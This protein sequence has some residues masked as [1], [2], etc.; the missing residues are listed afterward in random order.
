MTKG[1]P[2]PRFPT[3][4][5]LNQNQQAADTNE[6]TEPALDE[7]LPPG[8]RSAPAGS[9][10]SGSQ[11]P[12]EAADL[13]AGETAVKEELPQ[14]FGDYE[15]LEEIAR[16]GMGVVYRARDLKL[17]REVGLKMILNDKLADDSDIERFYSEA[18]SAAALKHPGVVPVYDVGERNGQHFFS[19]GFV[20][21]ESLA[22]LIARNPL[23]PT[24]SAQMVKKISEAI[25]YAHGEGVIHR[26]LKPANVLLDSKRNPHISDFGL[27]KKI[28]ADSNLTMPGQVIGTPSYMPPEQASGET[29]LIGP[30]ADV[31]SLGAVLYCCLTGR[32]PFQA[33][34]PME[35]LRQ[36][37]ERDP[38]PPRQLNVQIDRDLDT[39]CL[40]CLEKDPQRRYGSA[41]EIVDELERFLNGQPIR[42]RR[43]PVTTTLLTALFLTLVGGIAGINWWQK[44]AERRAIQAEQAEESEMSMDADVSAEVS[45][46]ERGQEIA[47]ALLKSE[48][49]DFHEANSAIES[50]TQRVIATRTGSMTDFDQQQKS[51]LERSLRYY[52]QLAERHLDDEKKSGT[53]IRAYSMSGEI[54]AAT[55][56]PSE[57]LQSYQQVLHLLEN[58]PDSMSKGDLRA[59]LGETSFELARL[60]GLLDAKI[61][62]SA[63]YSV[64]QKEKEHKNHQEQVVFL[65]G[66]AFAQGY[67]EVPEHL[68]RLKKDVHFLA[69]RS[70][71][72]GVKLFG[73]IDKA[74]RG[75]RK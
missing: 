39:I 68:D 16:G 62:G 48:R 53:V 34:N 6:V 37:V 56:R 27:A 54:L 4:E 57:A 55:E 43:I 70:T 52:Q 12:T 26:D 51:W 5:G 7:T 9:P 64:E 25:V 58:P 3:E 24:R 66:R 67:F 29:D 46:A 32:P 50:W 23:S 44:A 47:E 72:E 45:D 31:Y 75:E 35:T 8:W 49:L 63:D 41:Q 22:A 13:P 11:Q 36:V 74:N 14:R 18:R 21:G 59:M 69:F 65:L 42:A 71:S 30:V 15:L 38:V 33:A 2:K 28:T 40:K 19:M 60:H 17:D 1:D 73:E 20:E 10:L 61:Q